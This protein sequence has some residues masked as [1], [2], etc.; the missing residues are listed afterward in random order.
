MSEEVEGKDMGT[1]NVSLPNELSKKVDSLV[2]EGDYSSRS[3]LVRDALRSF[4]NETEFMERLS[5]IVLG[6]VAMIYT[7]DQ[8]GISDVLTRLQHRYSG[9]VLAT[10]HGHLGESC[11]EAVLV[12][13]EVSRIKEMVERIKAVKGTQ[14]VKIVVLS[15]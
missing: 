15:E 10:T 7:T 12:R 3:E 13:G 9:I 2:K 11:L 5:G 1:F 4:L 6:V 8:R 14:L